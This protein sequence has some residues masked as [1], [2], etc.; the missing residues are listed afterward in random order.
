MRLAEMRNLS[1]KTHAWIARF[2]EQT[3][4]RFIMESPI[5]WPPLRGFTGIA[6]PWK[7]S[8][9]WDPKR[10]HL[11]PNHIDCYILCIGR[12]LCVEG[13]QA[14]ERRRRKNT[15]MDLWHFT[16][17]TGRDPWADGDDL[18]HSGWTHQHNQSFKFWHWSFHGFSFCK[19]SKK[20]I[21][22]T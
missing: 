4:N 20:A 9:R 11:G 16:Y 12:E 17:M 6:P 5:P 18:W 13:T 22:Y 1:Y 7:F 10:H 14:R 19:G 21:L 15:H 2:T 8:R 3:W